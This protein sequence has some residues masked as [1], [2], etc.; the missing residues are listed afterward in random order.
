MIESSGNTKLIQNHLDRM[1]EE[2]LHVNYRSEDRFRKQCEILQVTVENLQQAKFDHSIY[3]QDTEP[4]HVDVIMSNATYFKD[5]DSEEDEDEDEES[6]IEGS[7][8]QDDVDFI[9]DTPHPVREVIHLDSSSDEDG[10]EHMEIDDERLRPNQNQNSQRPVVTA[11]VEAHP[12][13]PLVWP[14]LDEISSQ[15]QERGRLDDRPEEA[16]FVTVSGWDWNNLVDSQDRKRIVLKVLREMTE[17]ER[18]IIRVRLQI[19]RQGLL[20]ELAACTRMM[21]NKS[22]RMPGVMP[23]DTFKVVMWTKLFLSW[24]LGDNYM[25]K[26][27]DQEQL[28]ELLACLRTS[29]RDPEIFH[30]WVVHAM[31]NTFRKGSYNWK[32]GPPPAA[33]IIDLTLD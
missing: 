22:Q 26:Q 23:D 5:N 1:C 9:D 28:R 25:K 11:S 13:A 29:M 30:G 15:P 2:I 14:A 33:V 18:D 27:P 17:E 21:S 16:S 7:P 32:A 24:W 3:A 10:P 20:N 8:T 12:T 31:E 19:R 6:I 4:E